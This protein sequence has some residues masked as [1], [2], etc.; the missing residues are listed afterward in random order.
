MEGDGGGRNQDVVGHMEAVSHM[1]SLFLASTPLSEDAVQAIH[2]NLKQITD[3]IRCETEQA[4]QQAQQAQQDLEAEKQAQQA[5]PSPPLFSGG[6]V[7]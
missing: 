6:G 5:P 4:R 2:A 3:I 7:R 1:L